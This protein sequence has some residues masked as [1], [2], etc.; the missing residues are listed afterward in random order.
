M[1]ESD[2][3]WA[4]DPWVLIKGDAVF[5]LVP[6]ESMPVAER[7]N[8]LARLIIVLAIGAAL[9]LRKPWPLLVG[10]GLLL[11]DWLVY[12]YKES[13]Q[14]SPPPTQRTY[15]FERRAPQRAAQPRQPAQ[16]VQPL[17]DA[18]QPPPVRPDSAWEA[19]VRGPDE[20]LVNGESCALDG[21]N[22]A[23]A[24]QLKADH[25]PLDLSGLPNTAKPMPLSGAQW[26]SVP[27]LEFSSVP[28]GLESRR[29]PQGASAY[30]LNAGAP[31]DNAFAGPSA[32]PLG[33]PSHRPTVLMFQGRQQT[34]S[35]AN[36]PQQVPN[37]WPQQRA[38]PSPQQVAYG[39][40][41]PQ[42]AGPSNAGPDDTY[43]GTYAG[44]EPNF[45]APQTLAEEATSVPTTLREAA[46]RQP[47]VCKPWHLMNEAEQLN[48]LARQKRDAFMDRLF[49]DTSEG[50][51]NYQFQITANFNEFEDRERYMDAMYGK[52]SL[53]TSH[54]KD[55]YTHAWEK[56]QK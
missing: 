55:R 42:Q 33:Q 41:Q 13:T 9:L 2:R 37:Q 30:M 3:F 56:Y 8:A 51:N 35:T 32:R 45:G 18:E 50:I 5:E 48:Y 34:L 52:D 54:F 40:A 29:L 12:R 36:E 24:T 16:P 43:R 53:T 11:L 28:A 38:V 14:E 10:A 25:L 31:M 17:D 46:L 26:D 49:T 27:D 23:M 6:S 4:H 20:N 47:P 1:S 39:Y 44:Q 21:T 22:P 15:A 19:F 7:Y